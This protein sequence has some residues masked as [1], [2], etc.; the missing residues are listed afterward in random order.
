MD[1]AVGRK[2]EETVIVTVREEAG[3]DQSE[4]QFVC[5]DS[6]DPGT[7]SRLIREV[8][9]FIETFRHSNGAP[10]VVELRM[11]PRMQKMFRRAPPDPVL[12]RF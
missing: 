1:D 6:E 9:H 2:N 8:R 11:S 7:V 4:Q 3:G 10:R 12:R 5:C